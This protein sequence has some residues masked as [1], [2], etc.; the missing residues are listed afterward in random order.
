MQQEYNNTE[1]KYSQ[2]RRMMDYMNLTDT[3][4]QEQKKQVK[5]SF[6]KDLITSWKNYVY[7]Y[8]KEHLHQNYK[9]SSYHAKEIKP[10]YQLWQK[11]CGIVVRCVYLDFILADNVDDGWEEIPDK[12]KSKVGFFCY[13]L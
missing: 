5:Y 9:E 12:V 11:T 3:L 2:G 1:E 6:I 13:F 10:N 4:S 7:Q 8:L